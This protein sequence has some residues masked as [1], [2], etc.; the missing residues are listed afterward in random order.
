MHVGMDA[1]H[2]TANVVEDHF[3]QPEESEPKAL[4][5]GEIMPL[6]IPGGRQFDIVG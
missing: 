1:K 4:N 6:I 5:V 3:P 2:Q